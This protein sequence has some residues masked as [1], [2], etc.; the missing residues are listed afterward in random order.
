[1][2]LIDA[3]ARYRNEEGAGSNAYEWYRR[4]ANES[5]M[6]SIGKKK[7]RTWKS[8]G[9]WQIDD[10]EFASAIQSHRQERAFIAK[11][12]DDLKRGV[13]HGKDGEVICT[14]D[15]GYIRRD[16]FRF[17]WNSYEVGRRESNGTWYCNQ[18]NQPAQT[19]HEK[20]ECHLCAD[21][22]GCGR[23]CTLSEVS[24]GSCGLMRN[25]GLE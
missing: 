11:I 8:G 16:P 12:T 9:N 7:I 23:D 6:I 18:C 19:K 5:G 1:M 21:W 10:T 14:L 20:E 22:N 25:T 3:V 15:G 24:C 13:L 2:R 17:V 4:S